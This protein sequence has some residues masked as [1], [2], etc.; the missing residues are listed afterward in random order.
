M[1]DIYC[2]TIFQ[3]SAAS[4]FVL[5]SAA[6]N[7][8]TCRPKTEPNRLSESVVL[9]SIVMNTWCFH[10]LDMILL[11]FNLTTVVQWGVM[12]IWQREVGCN[13]G[14]CCWNPSVKRALKASPI[15]MTWCAVHFILSNIVA[16]EKKKHLYTAVIKVL[17]ILNHSLIHF[18][19]YY[20]KMQIITSLDLVVK[21]FYKFYK[22]L[23]TTL[24]V[25]AL[26]VSNIKSYVLDKMLMQHRSEAAISSLLSYL[27]LFRRP[28]EE[29]ESRRCQESERKPAETEPC[30][31][32]F[33]RGLS[34][35]ALSSCCL[36][37]HWRKGCE[38]RGRGSYVG[39]WMLLASSGPWKQAV[40]V[41]DHFMYWAIYISPSLF[42]MSVVFVNVIVKMCLCCNI[43]PYNIIHFIAPFD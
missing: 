18:Q 14:S 6:C 8:R 31:G 12:D 9:S 29:L 5:L 30:V 13:C 3:P 22:I 1:G 20:T 23:K 38:K 34:G 21:I 4:T 16:W 15:G 33:W 27:R 25:S 17:L 10:S 28:Q 41:K 11:L 26:T 2:V 32:V 42:Y 43:K 36:P 24:H 37:A 35:V 40:T 39:I 19:G 7:I